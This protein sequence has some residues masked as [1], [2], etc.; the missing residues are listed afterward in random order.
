M[1]ATNDQCTAL[2]KWATNQQLQVVL[3]LILNGRHNILHLKN[4]EI[5]K[6]QT[7]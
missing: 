7:H 5:R 1:I 6:L 2:L 4:K 3:E